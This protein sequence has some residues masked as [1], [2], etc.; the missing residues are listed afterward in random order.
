MQVNA[1]VT[2]PTDENYGVV[3]ISTDG[4]NP[5]QI[6]LRSLDR[7]FTATLTTM[8][9]R[10]LAQALTLAVASMSAGEQIAQAVEQMARGE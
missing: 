1:R 9:A 4:Q 3:E 7:G 8:E 2:I 6:S 10:R 5:I